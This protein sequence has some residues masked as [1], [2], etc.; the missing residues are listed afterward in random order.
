MS[1]EYG[2]NVLISGHR[3]YR[4]GFEWRPKSFDATPKVCPNCK[5]PYWDRPVEKIKI[6]KTI[7]ALRKKEKQDR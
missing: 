7:K 4:C 1:K 3:C 2:V 5:N 6:S